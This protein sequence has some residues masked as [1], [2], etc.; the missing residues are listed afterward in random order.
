MRKILSHL[1]VNQE[2][3]DKPIAMSHAGDAG[4]RFSGVP[5]WVPVGLAGVTAAGYSAY[6]FK[7]A[8][9]HSPNPT[10]AEYLR[11]NE[12]LLDPTATMTNHASYGA[13]PRRI[14]DK[15]M[16]LQL[17]MEA[18]PDRWF[19][20]TVKERMVQS[21]KAVGKLLNVDDECVGFVTNASMGVNTVLASYPFKSG[22]QV[23]KDLLPYTGVF[24][25]ACV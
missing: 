6:K 1:F 2:F 15:H 18:H 10:T 5:W 19:R 14:H 22:D 4:F 9:L 11:E 8:P 24:F 20:T 23:R 21:A 17:E 3:A 25:S 16:A 13:V 12:F 7:F